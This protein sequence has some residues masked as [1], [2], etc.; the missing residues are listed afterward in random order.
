MAT[1]TYKNQPGIHKTRG[2]VPLVGNAHLYKVGKVLWPEQVERVLHHLLIP[3]SLHVC[4]GKSLLGDVRFDNDP[5]NEPDVIGDASNLP[6]DDMQF[7][8]VLCDPP[9]NGKFQW[10]H[11]LL[12]ELG[13]VT[14]KRLIFQHWFLPADKLG[15][16]KKDH[17]LELRATFIWQPKTYFGRVQVISVFHR[18]RAPQK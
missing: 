3:E 2:S 8:S 15:R 13:R 10:N 14:R 11:D 6:F 12:S 9:Y 1:V 5:E 17:G 16:Y 4:C 7:N 18:V